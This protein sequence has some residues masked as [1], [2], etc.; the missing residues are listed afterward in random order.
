MGIVNIS[1]QIPSILFRSVEKKFLDGIVI[2]V[3][4]A[5]PD[6]FVTAFC[7]IPISLLEKRPFPAAI[8]VVGHGEGRC[9]YTDEL[10]VEFPRNRFDEVVNM[11]KHQGQCQHGH[12]VPFSHHGKNRIINQSIL[13]G[14][15]DD[16][17][18]DGSDV[19]MLERIRRQFSF[20][21]T[22]S[23]FFRQ[24]MRNNLQFSEHV[25]NLCCFSMHF[26][27]FLRRITDE[28]KC[29]FRWSMC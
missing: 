8:P 28:G 18:I 15:E 9:G 23:S 3:R 2:V 11:I 19:N 25:D 7:G 4:D 5:V 6:V 21:T 14:V 17:L 16:E 12:A 26:R 13:H 1:Q 20:V 10:P 29:T 22:H 24:G 27:C